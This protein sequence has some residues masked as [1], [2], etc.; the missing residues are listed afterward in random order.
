MPQE[1]QGNPDLCFLNYPARHQFT[2]PD[3]GYEASASHGVPVYVPAIA[4]GIASYPRRDGQAQAEMTRV[5]WMIY[6]S[7]DGHT[8]K[9]QTGP[10]QRQI[11]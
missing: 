3:D 1:S 8:Y 4:A 7:T 6:R 5:A 2:L 10:A 9:Y 11:D